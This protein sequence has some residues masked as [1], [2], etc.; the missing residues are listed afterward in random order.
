MDIYKDFEKLEN[1]GNFTNIPFILS[2]TNIYKK[3]VPDN[4]CDSLVSILKTYGAN[5]F[6]DVGVN[7]TS[8][9][10]G[11]KGSRRITNYDVKLAQYLNTLIP[12]F[13]L[14]LDEFSQVDWQTN[15]NDLLA[16]WEF[17]GVS[18]LFRFMEYTQGSE[19]FPHYDAPYYDKQQPLYRTLYSGILYLT[20]NISG[21]TAFVEDGQNNLPFKKRNTVDWEKQAEADQLIS[22]QLPEKGTLVIFPHQACHTVLPLLEDTSRIIIRF[23]I[24]FKAVG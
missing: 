24:F 18:P 21:A 1:K 16:K 20:D 13:S 2:P 15:N 10:E 17:V 8:L 19:H 14:E 12:R 23:D 4:I 9:T 7:G 5:S 6:Y 22:M 11:Q 3:I